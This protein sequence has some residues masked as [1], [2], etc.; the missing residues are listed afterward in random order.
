[1]CSLKKKSFEVSAASGTLIRPTGESREAF[2]M[3]Q[4]P[5]IVLKPIGVVRSPIKE[6]TDDCWGGVAATIALDAQ[7]FGP[8]STHGLD[9]FSHVEVIFLPNKIPAESVEKDA[10][11]PRGRTDWPKMAI[12]AQRSKD[13]PNRI[14]I[15]I[16]K[17]LFVKGLEIRASKLDAVDDTPVLDVKPYR[18]GFAPL[19]EV[20]EPAWANELMAGYFC[21]A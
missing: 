21:K 7:L 11:H 9:Q 19:G 3:N 5:D 4:S 10:R 16:C 8:E 13:R 17:L 14:G 18:K 6:V 15:N 20:R 12:F 2:G 1:M